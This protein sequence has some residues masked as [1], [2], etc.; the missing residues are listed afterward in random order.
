MGAAGMSVTPD[1]GRMRADP[2]AD[3]TIAS[4]LGRCGSAPDWQAINVINRQLEQWQSNGDLAGWQAGAGVPAH[5]AEPLEA[6]VRAGTTLPDWADTEKITRAETLF[7]D[8]GMLSCTLLFCSSLPECYVIPD[9]AAVLH[10]AGQLEQRTE[11][12]IRATAAMI[13]PV[14]MRGGMT[15]PAGAGLAQILKVRLIHATIRYLIMRGHPTRPDL[16]TLV[17]PLPAEPA[18]AG[19]PSMH[20]ALFAK[21]WDTGAEGLPCNQEELAYT[22]LTF[23]YVFLRSMRKLGLGLSSADEEAYLHAWNVMG[24]VLGIERDLMPASMAQAATMFAEIQARGRLDSYLPDP[25]PALGRDLM[26]TMEAVIPLRLLRPFPILLTRYLCGKTTARD[27]GIDHRV[28]ML[29]RLLFVAALFVTRGFDALVR[30][31]VPQFSLCR[32]FTRVVGYQFM[33][34]VLMDQS[35]PLKLPTALLDQVGRMTHAWQRDPKAPGW[36]NAVERN[37]TGRTAESAPGARP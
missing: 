25:R 6:F 28:S 36:V 37:L 24:H 3:E 16:C 2:L 21:G 5:M 13:F 34:K 7:Y 20:Q 19:A 32:M 35:R 27:I 9:L 18:P 12:R 14:M 30:L 31:A 4:I 22:L 15:T 8:Y 23:S 1:S 11:Y 17:A 26:R 29:S 33:E 10:V